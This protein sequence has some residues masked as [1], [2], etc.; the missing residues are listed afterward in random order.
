MKDLTLTEI[1]VKDIRFPTSKDFT[2]S[3]AMHKDPDYS[4]AYVIIKT[5]QANL[6]GHGLT[7]TLGR[8]TEIC[9]VAIDALKK[10]I[11]GKKLKDITQDMGNFWLQ[12]T[13][14]SQLRW[15][16]PDKGVMHL[17]VAALINAIWDLWAKTENKPVWR[18][19]ADFTPQEFVRCVPFKYLTDALTPE[20]AEDWLQQ[21]ADSKENRIKY[22]LRN[23]YPAYSTAAG[24]LG[25]SDEKLRYLAQKLV[26]EG[27]KHIKLKVGAN[28]DDDIRR[29]AIVREILGPK[30]FL[31]I[32]ANQIW[33]VNQAITW[34]KAL[35]P[36]DPWWIEE[37]TSPDDILGH[38]TIRKAVRPIKVATG[39]HCQNRV[40]FKQFFQARGIDICQID[41]CRL[42]GVNEVLAVLLLAAKF[43]IPVCPHA[44]GVGLCN[45]VQ[46]LSIIDYICVSASTQNRVIEYIDHL[47]EHF[48]HPVTVKNGRYM[49]PLEAG[50]SITL[51]PA[52][53][54]DFAYPNG[55][56]WSKK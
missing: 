23:G 54:D 15:L 12:L 20:E 29:C 9:V 28:L 8:G 52:T 19:V 41:S 18:L 17:A 56:V 25:Y 2:G 46:H 24:W 40:M 31:M 10:S 11:T 49:P 6:E 5:N 14:E 51:F 44:G 53:L 13:G 39:E 55:K 36:F 48:L 42:G 4:A 45:Y 1:V 30:L 38:A 35:K 50:Y 34:I 43:K 7:F 21:K 37:P 3:D 47:Q 33:D 22:L 32:D 16:G 26:D 27:W